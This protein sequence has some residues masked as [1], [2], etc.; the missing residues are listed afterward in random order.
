M[1]NQKTRPESNGASKRPPSDCII[2]I[3]TSNPSDFAPL[4]DLG[5]PQKRFQKFCKIQDKRLK[6]PLGSARRMQDVCEQIL[7]ELGDN[8]VYQQF[9]MKSHL[10]GTSKPRKTKTGDAKTRF[11]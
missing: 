1:P 2:H 8:D 11:Y 5:D 9:L 3:K 10:K 4:S 7:A 6:E